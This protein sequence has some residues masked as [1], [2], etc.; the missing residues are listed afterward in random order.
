MS[1][2]TASLVCLDDDSPAC[3]DGAR[4]SDSLFVKFS[5]AC[6]NRTLQ[7]GDILLQAIV[8]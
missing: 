8:E 1:K 2:E 6:L 3:T 7:R 4:L 5:V